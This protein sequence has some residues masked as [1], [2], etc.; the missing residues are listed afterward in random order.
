MRANLID[1]PDGRLHG[2]FRRLLHISFSVFLVLLDIVKREWYPNWREH[3]G[4]CAAGKA[5]LHIELRLMVSIFY[6]TADA[7]HYYTIST[8]TNISEEVHHVF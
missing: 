5:V 3:H 6:L 2:K 4:I 7:S 1:H 8:I